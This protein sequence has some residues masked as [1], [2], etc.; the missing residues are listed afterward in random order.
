MKAEMQAGTDPASE[1]VQALTKRWMGLVQEFTGGNPAI[2]Q[3]LNKMYHNEPSVRQ[4][5]GIDME[6][7]AYVSQ[8]MGA[9]KKGK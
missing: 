3:A 7:M 6:L 1:R 8:A 9:G 5:T 2:G 4:Q